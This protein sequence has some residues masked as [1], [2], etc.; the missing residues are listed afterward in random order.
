MSAAVPSAFD[1]TGKVSLVTGGSR[2]LGRSMAGALAAAGAEIVIVSRKQDSCE[3]AAREIA[4]QT[5]VRTMAHACHVSHWDEIERLVDAVY[6]RFGRVDVLVNNAGKSPLYESLLDITEEMW[7]SVLGV[8]LLGPFRLST[9]I[10]TR[11]VEAGSGSIINISTVGSVLAEPSYLP[12]A[13]AKSGLNTIT[14]AFAKSFAPTVRVN[15][16]MPGPFHTDVTASWSEDQIAR[17]SRSV[18]LGRVGDPDDINGAVLWLAG[19]ASAYVTGQV[20]AVD[21]GMGA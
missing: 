3:I 11:M 7:N 10:G 5:G 4:Q 8:N 18:P 15:C 1:L 12:Y 6:E 16:I 9:L 2:G 13:A 20:F 14:R 17:I 21:G 19:A